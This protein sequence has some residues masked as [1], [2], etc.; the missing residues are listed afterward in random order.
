MLYQDIL[1]HL[2]FIL[3][4]R[5]MEVTIWNIVYFWGKVKREK[6][7][8]FTLAIKYFSKEVIYFLSIYS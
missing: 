1:V 7:A 6:K 4:P 3:G 5:L 8:C 2:I